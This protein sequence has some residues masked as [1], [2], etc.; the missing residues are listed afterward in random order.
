M[1][2][3]NLFVKWGTALCALGIFLMTSCYEDKGNYNYTEIIDSVKFVGLDPVYL[4]DLGGN[5]TITPTMDPAPENESGYTYEWIRVNPVFD[6]NGN[7]ILET[8]ST[9]KWLEDVQIPQL[10]VGANKM[11]YVVTDKRGV[12]YPSPYFTI[13]VS[14]EY[15]TGFLVMVNKDNKAGVTFINYD[16]AIAGMRDEIIKITNLPLNG[17]PE[18]GRGR[19]IIAHHDEAS[20]AP[21]GSAIN[22]AGEKITGVKYAITL[23]TETGFYKL[24]PLD[25]TYN[26]LYH[27]QYFVYGDFSNTVI[28]DFVSPWQGVPVST[29]Q[30]NMYMRDNANNIYYYRYTSGGTT[31]APWTA[32]LYLNRYKNADGTFTG[33][34]AAKAFVGSN[35]LSNMTTFIYDK[36]NRCFAFKALSDTYCQPV[37]GTGPVFAVN[38]CDPTF[39]PIWMSMR[40]HSYAGAIAFHGFTTTH[41]TYVVAKNTNGIAGAIDLLLFDGRGISNVTSAAAGTAN[42]QVKIDIKGLKDIANAKFYA[43]NDLRN[44]TT[45]NP[46]LATYRD[47]FYY[48]TDKSVYAYNLVEGHNDVRYTVDPSETIVNLKFVSHPMIGTCPFTHNLMVVSTKNG[49]R[50]DGTT[51]AVTIVRLFTIDTPVLYGNLSPKK[52]KDMNGEETNEVCEWTI[53][54]EYVGI[55]WKAKSA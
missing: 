53:D 44:N 16:P 23:A 36:T 34:E 26:D 1:K 17:I 33:F 18:L 38:N 46:T 25:L 39:E 52:L 40:S 51:G 22:V 19:S 43:I 7:K 49:V 8:V 29:S 12:K 3:N 31:H 30:V 6:D 28:T 9:D 42:A 20:P 45:I 48:A 11:M 47:L 21:D 41:V 55:D 4:M 13:D 35:A 5:I 15:K 27:G 2:R 24:S 37:T 50:S 10:N 32:G 14:N 54:G